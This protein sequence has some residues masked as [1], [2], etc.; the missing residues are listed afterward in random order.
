M[1][2][3]D[4]AFLRLGAVLFLDFDFFIMR[5]AFFFAPFLGLRFRG[6]QITRPY[7]RSPSGNKSSQDSTNPITVSRQCNQD[8]R[9]PQAAFGVRLRDRR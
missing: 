8:L 7:F 1:D 6:K 9:V 4:G 2:G 5:F 3:G